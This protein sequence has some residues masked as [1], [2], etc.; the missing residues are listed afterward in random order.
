VACA[1][2]GLLATVVFAWVVFR[3][4]SD[5]LAVEPFLGD[6]YDAQARS[7]LHGHWD[8]PW[9]PLAFERFNI[10]GKFYTYFGPWPA[11]LRMPVV[12][13]TNEFDGRLSRVSMLLAFVVLLVFTARL[14]WQ[15]RSLVRGDG[16]PTRATLLAA[17][18][19]VF[20]A[21]CGSTALFLASRAWTHHEA[22]SWGLAWSVASFSFVVSYLVAPR[23]RH[24]VWAC[25]TA[26]LALLSR[27]SIGTGPVIA[28]GALLA[29]GL[30]QRTIG[31]WRRRHQPNTSPA[32]TTPANV[33]PPSRRLALAR[34][35]GVSDTVASR[36]IWPVAVA[37]AAPVVLYAYVNYSKFGSLFGLPSDKQ[38]IL[39]NAAARRA[40]LAA[41][42][43]LF[44]LK[45]APTNLLQYL[46]P[47][48]I[49]FDRLFPWVTFSTP[50]IIGNTPYDNIDPSASIS[51][52]STVLVVLAVVG[53]VAA[54]RAPRPATGDATAAV[55]R[56]PILAAT[57]ATA[58]T[59]VIAE[60]IQRYEGDFVPVLVLAGAAGLFWLPALVAH[61]GRTARTLIAGAL[62]VVAA[63]SCWATFA[64]TL[65]YQR[66]YSGIQAPEMRA[67]FVNFQLDVNDALGLGP[68][69]DVRHGPKLPHLS[70]Q[71]A[72]RTDAPIGRFF[73]VGN[74]D[75]V[76]VSNGH[77]WQP[78][79]EHPSGARR[80]R[81]AFDAPTP[82]TRQPLCSTTL[83]APRPNHIL[84]ANWID[85]DHIRIEYQWTGAPD[86]FAI[87]Q[88][89]RVKP[90][91]R[92]DLDVH[93]DP[94][95]HYLEVTYGERVLL[96]GF[97]SVFD[98]ARPA[99]LGRQ[100]VSTAGAT[101]LDGTIRELQTTSL[102]ERLRASVHR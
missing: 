95:Q 33:A 20:V 75:G 1:V 50:H 71:S 44:S 96:I 45:Y 89:M 14:A 13:F 76:Y 31:W 24:L 57:L 101:T 26:T 84:W 42:N 8:V 82:G 39:L 100:D 12:A 99:S 29:V 37:F 4:S 6:F 88:T 70:G 9:H 94:A 67:G 40:A 23:G 61:R 56:I 91:Q 86:A 58:G 65:R 51:A 36:A 54:I 30:L 2:G 63:W 43:Q 55:L 98:A 18:G 77:E 68:P 53:I 87:G 19:F 28:L 10:G 66:V 62:V 5:L 16:P 17:G 25:V 97:P 7:L 69:D 27:P 41:S 48:G 38:D 74:C 73:I 46:R 47:D 32:G 21:G 102:C 93:L 3:G 34:W 64:L 52:V 11:I 59:I 81:V 92:Y 79:E 49:A 80:W 72:L 60:L 35:L 85:E 22:I 83:P 90:G 78:V 15:A